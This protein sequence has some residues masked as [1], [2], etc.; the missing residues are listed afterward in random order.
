MKALIDSDVLLDVALR[1]SPWARHSNAV[2]RLCQHRALTGLVSWHSLANV[3][4]LIEHQGGADGRSFIAPLLRFV[5]VAAVGHED[6]ELAL[7]LEMADLEDAMQ[8]AAAVACG[9]DRIITRNTKD[10][11]GSA[12]PAITPAEFL[13]RFAVQPGEGK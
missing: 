6:M 1:R 7:R 3:F 2:L 11:A 4:Y 5:E 8:V 13:A 9:A 10:F 12:I